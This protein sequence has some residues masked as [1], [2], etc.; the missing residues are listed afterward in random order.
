MYTMT[1]RQRN[2]ILISLPFLFAFMQGSTVHAQTGMGIDRID[3]LIRTEHLNLS[4]NLLYD[5]AAGMNIAI[6]RRA[7]DRLSVQLSAVYN[8]FT[9]KDGVKWKNWVVQPE[10]RW[11]HSRPMSGSFVAFHIVGGEF[12]IQKA[13]LL[14]NIF[15]ETRTHRFEG[16]GIGAGIGYGYRWSF[17]QHI[18]MEAEIAVGVVQ[19]HYNKYN[20][21]KCGERLSKGNYTY[22]GPTKLAISL[23]YRFGTGKKKPAKP[24]KSTIGIDQDTREP[25]S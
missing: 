18:G 22:V 20:C 11:W 10:L 13:R 19:A 7:S 14:Y 12:N 6:E 5:A 21:R 15:R 16:W 1:T 4:T 3:T 8:P 2:S 24:S 17:N 9:F 23:I 25:K